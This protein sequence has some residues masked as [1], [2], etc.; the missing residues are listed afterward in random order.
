MGQMAAKLRHLYHEL[1]RHKK[2][3]WYVRVGHGPRTPI[4]ERHGTDAFFAAYHAALAGAPQPAVQPAATRAGTLKWLTVLHLDSAYWQGL[5]PAT[6]RQRELILKKVLAGA[7]GIEIAKI[8]RADIIAGRDRRK[9]T[10]TAAN[11]YINVMR[12]LFRWAVSEGHMASDPTEGVK[13]AKEPKT[14]GFEAWD[15]ADI[16]A[17]KAKWP[18]GT[19]EYVAL[20]VVLGTGARR[21]DASKL[22]PAHL[23]DGGIGWTTE[24]TGTRVR[25]PVIPELREALEKCPIGATTFITSSIGAP[26]VK[27]AFGNWFGRICAAAGVNKSAHGLRK[28]CATRLADAGASEAELDAALGWSPGSKMASVYTRNRDVER[29]AARAFSRTHS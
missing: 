14:P 29:L 25:L 7:G 18:L 19:R 21:G 12:G 11:H 23:V 5:K 15:E 13:G 27:A 6:R 4:K 26:F 1:N 28:L 9:A 17:F 2:R 20:A 10:P 22:G 24:K 3:V 16:K 8:N